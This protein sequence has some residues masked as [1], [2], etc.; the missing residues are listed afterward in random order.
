MA[1]GNHSN[2]ISDRED[3]SWE[4]FERELDE[5]IEELDKLIQERIVEESSN[6]NVTLIT[7]DGLACKQ[8]MTFPNNEPSNYL[9]RAAAEESG[10]EF[11]GFFNPDLLPRER[12]YSIRVYQLH[13]CNPNKKEAIYTEM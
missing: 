4:D 7:K 6:W 9:R 12:E 2:D 10:K 1:F 3:F 5:Q 11:V 8:K 13:Q